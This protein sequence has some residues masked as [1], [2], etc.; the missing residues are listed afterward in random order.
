MAAARYEAVLFDLLTA[1]L[2]SWDL[3]NDV[4]GDEESGLRWRRE[5]LRLTYGASD[6]RPY[7]EIVAEAARNASLPDGVADELAAR[8]DELSPWPE[9]P[10]VLGELN[11]RGLPMGV[12]TNCSEELGRRAAARAGANFRVLVTA[13]RAGFYKPNPS[14]YRLALR[15]LGVPPERVL[16]VAGSPSDVPGASG[17]GMPVV[18]HNRIGLPPVRDS[19]EPRATYP[20]LRPLVAEVLGDGARGP[21]TPTAERGA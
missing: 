10:E 14:P 11:D 3:W 15:E 8:W 18:W 20:T 19:K 4:A 7:E 17:A 5:Y 1:L 12:V 9:V 16:F 21:K 13:E 2:D 6:Y